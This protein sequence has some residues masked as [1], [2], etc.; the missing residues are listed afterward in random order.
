MVMMIREE[1]FR[2]FYASYK[3]TVV[4]NALFTAV[5]FST[6]EAV[7]KVLSEVSPENA[8]EERIIVHVTAGGAARALAGAV[9]TLLDVVKIRLQCQVLCLNI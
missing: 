6:Y 5:H 3:N 2:A 7:K 4:M 1:G 8:N 9:T